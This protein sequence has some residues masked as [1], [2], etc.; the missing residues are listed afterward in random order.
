MKRNLLSCIIMLCS[1]LTVYA[2]NGPILTLDSGASRVGLTLINRTNNEA[3]AVS[4]S[5]DK[6]KLPAWLSVQCE[7][8]AVTVPGGSQSARKLFL[9][10]TL[11]DAP[12]NAEFSVPLTL[13]DA[14][15]STWT[16][17]IRVRSAASLPCPDALI[18]NYPNPFNPDTAISFSLASS[19]DTRLVI[20]NALGQKVRVLADGMVT[21]GKH[22]IRWDGKNDAGQRVSSGVYYYKLSA[23]KFAEARKMVLV[24]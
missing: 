3:V 18:G 6:A 15:G 5:V 19:R 14:Y 21:A 24:E 8:G 12:A 1:C 2:D 16:Q 11:A 17:Q 9:V 22:T 7:P 10:F 23:G 20:Y 13:R 4:A